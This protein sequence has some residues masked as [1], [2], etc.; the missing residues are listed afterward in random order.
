MSGTLHLKYM[1]NEIMQRDPGVTGPQAE[2]L[3]YIWDSEITEIITASLDMVPDDAMMVYPEIKDEL[4]L[5]FANLRLNMANSVLNA[6]DKEKALSSFDPEEEALAV[7]SPKSRERVFNTARNV[8]AGCWCPLFKR[9]NAMRSA[10]G[11]STAPRVF[12]GRAIFTPETESNR[13]R[14]R[15]NH[16]IPRFVTKKWAD[17]NGE[18]LLFSRGIGEELVGR[19]AG[20]TTWAKETNLYSQ[21]IEDLLGGIECDATSPYRKFEEDEPLDGWDVRQWITF[22]ICQ[23]LRNPTTVAGIV[24]GTDGL[25]RERGWP[26]AKSAAQR[27]AAYETLFFHDSFYA[28]LYK[29]VEARRWLLVEAP[30]AISFFLGDTHLVSEGPLHDTKSLL[31]CPVSPSK[32][33]LAGPKVEGDQWPTRYR[34]T[35]I[36]AEGV[37]EIN[38]LIASESTM[39]IASITTT[40][41][42][43]DRFLAE[44][45]GVSRTEYIFSSTKEAWWGDLITTTRT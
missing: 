3:A 36:E 2:A 1:V 22:I 40:R 11:P 37:A 24:G 34:P 27:R 44:H 42:Q 17:I 7:R 8:H 20:H 26:R 4:A 21:R 39:V 38:R 12:A 6:K 16:F 41:P 18:V 31:L 23:W 28:R 35:K 14:T 15:Y 33:F 9:W 43:V 25:C 45:L 5:R 13:T 32:C 19:R 10:R 29:S 30:A